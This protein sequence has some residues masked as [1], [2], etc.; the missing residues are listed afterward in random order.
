MHPT[1]KKANNLSL[2]RKTLTPIMIV[3]PEQDLRQL[4]DTWLRSWEF[5][6]ITFTDGGKQCLDY[7]A[8]ISKDSVKESNKIDMIIILGTHVKDISYIQIVKQITNREFNRQLILTTTLP[9]STA[10]RS[11]PFTDNRNNIEMII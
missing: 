4:Y 6:Y 10:R 1:P 9:S 5:K 7:L 2:A 3:E 8:T 11:I